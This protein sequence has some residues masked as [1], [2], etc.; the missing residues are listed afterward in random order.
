MAKYTEVLDLVDLLVAV[1]RSESFAAYY[2]GKYWGRH[3]PPRGFRD[4]QVVGLARRG[5][6]Y[7]SR[8][9]LVHQ[10]FDWG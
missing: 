9:L 7:R 5:N 2:S 4:A 10:H 6:V 3:I 1:A 8:H